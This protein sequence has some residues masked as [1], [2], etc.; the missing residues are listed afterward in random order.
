MSSIRRSTRIREKSS[1]NPRS[2]SLEEIDS[3]NGQTPATNA[4]IDVDEEVSVGSYDELSEIEGDESDE[5]YEDKRIRNKRKRKQQSTKK[6]SKVN[7]K[8]KLNAN[9]ASGNAN[10]KIF[11]SKEEQEEYVEILKTFE[12]TELFE[13]LASSEDVSIDELLRDLL[14]KYKENKDAFIQDFVNLILCCSGVITRVEEH[15]VRNNDAAHET[16]S[17]IQAVFQRQKIHEFYLLLS[18]NQKKKSKY[19][20]LYTNFMELMN[21]MMDMANE[22][23]LL[24]IDDKDEDGDDIIITGPFILDILTWLSSFS[25]CKIRCLRYVS[26]LI[27]YAFQDSIVNQVVD[28]E[29]NYLVK[30]NKQL[31]GEEKR[32]RSN[33]KTI[34]KIQIIISEV[35]QNKVIMEGIIDSIIKLAFIHRFKDVDEQIRS[36]SMYHLSVWTKAYPEYFLK[37]TFL[38]YFGWLLS[39][40]SFEVRL[41]ILKLLPDIIGNTINSK[42][43][44]KSNYDISSV[45]QFFERFQDRILDIAEMD[46]NLEVRINAVQVL[47][48]IV[49]L[50]YLE[51]DDIL[52][53]SSLIFNEYEIKVSSHGKNS[54]FL[55]TIA[56]FISEVINSRV[57]EFK[58]NYTIKDTV[59]GMPSDSIIEIGAMMYL[60]NQSLV[61]YLENKKNQEEED[62]SESD[63]NEHVIKD[64]GIT[65]QQK[66]Y[67]LFQSAEFLYPFFGKLIGDICKMLIYD[68]E[69]RI[70]ELLEEEEENKE[71]NENITI[72]LPRE[73]ED[74]ILYLTVLKGLCYGGQYGKN[75]EKL[76]IA[77]NVLPNIDKLFSLLSVHSSNVYIPIF[78]IIELFGYELWIESGMNEEDL[79]KL[80]KQIIKIFEDMNISEDIN[81][82]EY[83]S[84]SKIISHIKK[85][86]MEQLDEIIINFINK[87]KLQLTTYLTERMNDIK[88]D[89]DIEY[90]VVINTVF[91]MFIN[92]LVLLGKEY[93]I[94]INKELF[95]KINEIIINNITREDIINNTEINIIKMINFKFFSII[96]NWQ[97][98]KWI[99]I[100]NE[101]GDSDNNTNVVSNESISNTVKI[102]SRI[103][104]RLNTL[105][106]TIRGD[107]EDKINYL[108]WKVTNSIIDISV[109]I[110]IYELN[111]PKNENI[112]IKEINDKLPYLVYP[113]GI[114]IIKDVYLILES[115]M[116]N[117]LGERLDRLADEN[118]NYNNIKNINW[119]NTEK[120]ESEFLIYTIKLRSLVK[121]NILDEDISDRLEL[122]KDK[123]GDIYTTIVEK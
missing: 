8:K 105:L 79:I 4:E 39:D 123:L 38:K 44:L 19:P 71:D 56:K 88:E 73:R 17:E 110:K 30:L 60:L 58:N 76:E 121:L 95:D 51:D 29:R 61:F 27:F 69:Y 106:V 85:F 102:F 63:D 92:K 89:N 103:I 49:S 41:Q 101:R 25:V 122:N 6:R 9:D 90:S 86:N 22:L 96:V 24:C 94:E 93:M 74:V 43:Q 35:Q 11:G 21:K 36:E 104:E 116:G 108:R 84:F 45:R 55:S 62:G 114:E 117:K 23:Q 66:I 7:K 77:E 115:Y 31:L 120:I 78:S 33:K 83:E 57:E 87:L 48:K 80:V 97:I 65:A 107:E 50:G 18:K 34:K 40:T 16:V 99:E 68:G 91:G 98:N 32:K 75:Q 47:V 119:I 13:I 14:N 5:D 20:H 15:D 1:V 59:F 46:E 113:R 42:G 112:W 64:S 82:E 70:E 3:D 2:E 52:K 72:L 12:T 81:N 118:V 67:T 109:G 100:M 54:R 53:I 26:T 28:L 10:D 37:V 111:L